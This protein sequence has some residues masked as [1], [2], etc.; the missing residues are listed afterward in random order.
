MRGQNGV[1]YLESMIAVVILGIVAVAAMPNLSSIDPKKLD[2]AAQTIADA[3]VFARA[4]AIRK[5][6]PQGI[7]TDTVNERIR[8]YSLPAQTAVFDVY[9]PIDKKIYDIQLKTDTQLA[10][11]DLV[12]ANFSYDGSLNSSSYLD[13][14]SDGIPKLTG[15]IPQRDYMLISASI[16][17]AYHGQQRQISIAPIT[18]RVAVQ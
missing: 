1:T 10:G 6:I 16:I 4:D 2:V 18:G 3:I 5:K 13:F 17:I 7:N 8:V 11:V 15:G 14:N 12:S 9:H